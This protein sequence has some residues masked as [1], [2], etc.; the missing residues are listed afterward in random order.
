MHA[1]GGSGRRARRRGE[2]PRRSR[3]AARRRGRVH[4][5]RSLAGTRTGHAP[6]RT[7]GHRG[8]GRRGEPVSRR[9]QRRQPV[10]A[11]RVSRR[12]V[13]GDVDDTRRGGRGQ[14]R[15][16][17][18]GRVRRAAREACRHGGARVAAPVLPAVGH[19]RHR[20]E[21]QPLESGRPD[22]QAPAALGIHGRLVPGERV[23]LRGRR[24]P[25]LREGRRRAWPGGSRGHRRARGRRRG[26]G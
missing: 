5:R 23:R 3:A 20:R 16:R 15:A 17:C 14:N 2:L 7:A 24:H 13:S 8:A 10:D 26:G 9:N 18:R 6:A 25:R 11:G 19:R 1:R 4:G 21:P 22:L 12:R